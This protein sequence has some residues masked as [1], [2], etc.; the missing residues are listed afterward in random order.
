MKTKNG[1]ITVTVLYILTLVL[2]VIIVCSLLNLEGNQKLINSI[3][4]PL[5]TLFFGISSKSIFKFW[6]ISPFNLSEDKLSEIKYVQNCYLIG[7]LC[8]DFTTALTLSI[9][10]LKLLPKSLPLNIIFESIGLF[11]ILVVT[12]FISYNIKPL[13]K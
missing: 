3:T 2:G 1:I 7:T 9:Y 10:I 11:F 6:L 12:S 5:I 8:A 13:E 4:V